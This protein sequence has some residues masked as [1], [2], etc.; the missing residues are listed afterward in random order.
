MINR[1]WPWLL[2]LLVAILVLAAS[3][4]PPAA[5]QTPVT[6]SPGAPETLVHL[7]DGRTVTCL[8]FV[9]TD[10]SRAVSCDWAHAK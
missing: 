6:P 9:S 5:G 2:G 10:N 4:D 7:S 8:M 1:Y 3:C